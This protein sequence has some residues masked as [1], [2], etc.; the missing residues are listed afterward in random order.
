MREKTPEGKVRGD[1][2]GSITQPNADETKEKGGGS[3]AS[4]VP[5]KKGKSRSLAAR[6]GSANGKEEN[7]SLREEA[8]RFEKKGQTRKGGT[9][10]GRLKSFTSRRG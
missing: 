10:Q 5:S 7:F 6:E 1:G 3:R 2:K 4:P 9:E 8:R